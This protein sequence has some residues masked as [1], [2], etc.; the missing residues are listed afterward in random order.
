MPSARTRRSRRRRGGAEGRVLGGTG[1]GRA[2]EMGHTAASGRSGYRR[3]RSE[4]PPGA[5]SQHTDTGT[6]APNQ[7]PAP[8]PSGEP[9]DARLV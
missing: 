2:R 9:E 3:Q 7:S 5:Q 6:R 1:A 4:G 8:T